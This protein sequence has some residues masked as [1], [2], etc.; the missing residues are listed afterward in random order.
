M[1]TEIVEISRKYNCEFDQLKIAAAYV[2][3]D[4]TRKV[5]QNI[6]V[7][8]RNG[9]LVAVATDGH[10][11]YKGILPENT[12][13]EQGLYAVRKCNKSTLQLERTN[14]DTKYPDYSLVI[15][16]IDKPSGRVS[17]SFDQ[18]IN[19]IAYI[20]ASVGLY[21]SLEYYKQMPGAGKVW[22]LLDDPQQPVVI[23]GETPSDLWVL[24]PLRQSSVYDIDKAISKAREQSTCNV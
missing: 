17:V 5:L 11:L 4:K 19:Q 10:T 6:L 13:L 24:M 1:K 12:T 16:D 14:T 3:R 20:V 21:M 23:T 2:S 15:P 18:G 9:L 22:V 7:E 8:E